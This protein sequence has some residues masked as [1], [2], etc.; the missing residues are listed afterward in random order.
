MCIYRER[1]SVCVCV[2]RERERVC[3]YV[4]VDLPKTSKLR[5][6]QAEGSE[7]GGEERVTDEDE[8]V[9]AFFCWEFGS[10]MCGFVD[11][12]KLRVNFVSEFFISFSFNEVVYEIY[13]CGG[14]V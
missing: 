2:N 13:H 1:K 7:H 5:P 12:R 6:A 4:R 9:G 8:T 3:V 11:F 14:V 10:F